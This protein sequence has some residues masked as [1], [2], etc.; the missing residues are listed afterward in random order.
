MMNIYK[1]TDLSRLRLFF[2][3]NVTD[4]IL[5]NTFIHQSGRVT[6]RDSKQIRNISQFRNE[7]SKF[8]YI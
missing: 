1:L 7:F 3:W 6:D 5:M 2:R 4:Q 8:S